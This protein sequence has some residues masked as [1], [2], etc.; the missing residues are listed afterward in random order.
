MNLCNALFPSKDLQ[1]LYL[2]KGAESVTVPVRKHSPY[3]TE[4]DFSCLL[5]FLPGFRAAGRSQISSRSLHLIV[6]GC[7]RGRKCWKWD[8]VQSGPAVPHGIM[9][10]MERCQGWFYLNSPSCRIALFYC[11]RTGG[12]WGS[13][14]WPGAVGWAGIHSGFQG[15]FLQPLPQSVELC[16]FLSASNPEELW[17]HCRVRKREI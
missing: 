16:W 7:Y 5:Q 2:F 6:M 17:C 9:S 1:L 13:Q 4:S 10:G 8:M 11:N 12:F 14:T 15:T 3:K